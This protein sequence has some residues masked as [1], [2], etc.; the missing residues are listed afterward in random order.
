MT[1]KRKVYLDDIRSPEQSHYYT[2]K[3]IYLDKDWIVVRSYDEFVKDIEENGVCDTYSFDHDLAAAHYDPDLYGSE[4]YNEIYDNFEEKT[5]YHCA[6][7]L[8]NH[9]I[10]SG[11]DVPQNIYIHSMNPDG[12]LNIE[13]EFK[14]YCKVFGDKL[15][16]IRYVPRTY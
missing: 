8:I 12:G 16:I 9:C 6:K 15:N 13:S 5:G 11:I 4:T 10:D 7:Y 3:K 2:L 14:T 1:N